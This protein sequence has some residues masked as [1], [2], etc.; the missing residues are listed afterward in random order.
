MKRVYAFLKHQDSKHIIINT[1]GNY[2]NTFF[3]VFTVYILVR[4]LSPS[5]YGVL[6]VLLGIAYV[7]ANILDFGTTATIYSYLPPLLENRSFGLYRFI[8]STF[9]YQTLFSFFIIG[10]LFIFFPFLDKVFFKTGAP[11]IELYL[12]AISVLFF[13]WQNFVINCLF[14][15]K[16]FLKTNVYMLI[17]NVIKT[18]VIFGLILTHTASIGNIIFVFG[19]LGPVIFFALLF[20]EKKELV[21]L[22]AKSDVRRE[23]F[24]FRYTMTYFVASQFLNL[25]LRMDLF[26]LSY[27]QMGDQVGFYG[28][29][30]KIIL[31]IMTTV[32]SITQVLS[33][34]FSRVS[35]KED[36]LHKLKTGVLYLLGPTALFIILAFVPEFIFTA[37]FTQKFSHTT[38]IT[39]ALA[40]PFII[41]SISNLPLLFLLYTVKKPRYILYANIVFFIILT[42]GC[43]ILIP[44]LGMYGPPYA[45]GAG[46]LAAT[47][48]MSVAS[49]VEYRHL[50]EPEK[51]PVRKKRGSGVVAA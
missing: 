18:L 26:L 25:G 39:H 42:A 4:I 16:H 9:F 32:I 50:P 36:I 31:T 6:S 27:F 15:A 29:A 14:A 19:I 51:I 22:L 10:G 44:S 38:G 17:S 49:F 7:L 23:E 45:I 21:F 3:T 40:I 41:Y 46:L 5:E 35:T 13:I 34:S 47:I 30:Q 12:T 24:R 33:P 8:K 11:V 48:I 28:L 2:V 37:F 1:I 43:Y 20:M